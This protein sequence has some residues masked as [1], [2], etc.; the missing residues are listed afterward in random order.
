M[1][2][3]SPS[4]PAFPISA[5]DRRPPAKTPKAPGRIFPTRAPAAGMGSPFQRYPT[6]PSARHASW[7]RNGNLES[8]SILLAAVM[9]PPAETVGPYT[10]NTA[11]INR[12]DFGKLLIVVLFFFPP[13]RLGEKRFFLGWNNFPPSHASFVADDLSFTQ[14]SDRTSNWLSNPL[15]ETGLGPTHPPKRLTV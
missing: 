15:T 13:E 9:G 7:E 14:T 1:N 4:R 3:N 6:L 8:F 5:F 10:S 12:W 11:P 2:L